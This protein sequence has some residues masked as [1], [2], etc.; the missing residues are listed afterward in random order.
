MNLNQS[1]DLAAYRPT[2]SSAVA[3]RPRDAS[4]RLS[5]CSVPTVNSKTKHLTT[6]RLSVEAKRVRSTWQS[7]FEAKRSW[8]SVTGTE[9][10]QLFFFGAHRE[11]CVDSLKTKTTLD[12]LSNTMLQRKCVLFAIIGQQYSKLWR[13][14]SRTGRSF[15]TVR[16]SLCDYQTVRLRVLS[17]PEEASVDWGLLVILVYISKRESAR[18]WDWCAVQVSSLSRVDSPVS[19]TRLSWIPGQLST[20]RQALRIQ[21]VCSCYGSMTADCLLISSRQRR[22]NAEIVLGRNF[23][24]HGAI[25]FKYRA[26]YSSFGGGYA[27]CAVHYRC[28]CC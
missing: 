26:Q 7:N 21:V 6:F 13:I 8:I 9:I 12:V 16:Q 11:K 3:E 23:A 19:N 27:C 24:A 20:A 4:V 28:S 5:S 25:S 2:R 14:A 10:W 17:A 22:G 1:E 18:Y 15:G